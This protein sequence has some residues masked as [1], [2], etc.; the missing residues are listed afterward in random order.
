MYIKL[1]RDGVKFIFLV[2]FNEINDS[3]KHSL[4]FMSSW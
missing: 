3:I 1:I 4:L 2:A